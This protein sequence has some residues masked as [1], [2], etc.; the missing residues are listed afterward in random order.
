MCNYFLKIDSTAIYLKGSCSD[1]LEFPD[2]D[3]KFNLAEYPDR[4]SF[5]IYNGTDSSRSDS[6]AMDYS[7]QPSTSSST[8]LGSS[9]FS[10]KRALVT[11]KVVRADLVNKKLQN[12]HSHNLTVHIPIW[13]EA[14]AN[15]E[16]ITLKVG[17]EMNDGSL[18]IVGSSGLCI[19]DQEGTR[20]KVIPN[21][22]NKGTFS[23]YVIKE[24]ERLNDYA[25]AKCCN[26]VIT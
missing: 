18:V 10:N 24:G 9:S 23:Y 7:Q 2:N 21:M 25:S 4:T 1:V 19:Y 6:S 20:G 8:L 14:D 13:S 16:Y 22:I 26:K 11:V 17:E 12:I 3:G 15:V 5:I